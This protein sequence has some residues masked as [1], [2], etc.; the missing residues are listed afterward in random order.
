MAVHQYKIKGSRKKFLNLHGFPTKRPRLQYKCEPNHIF[1]PRFIHNK[2]LNPFISRSVKE[3][4][5][6][7]DDK[8]GGGNDDD[9]DDD[10]RSNMGGC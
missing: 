10:C 2:F 4:M 7:V 8:D 5:Y 1:F 9:D 6:T 3:V